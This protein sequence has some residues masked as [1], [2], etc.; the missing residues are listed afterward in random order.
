MKEIAFCG[1][2]CE[3]C[4]KFKDIF[5]EKAKEI[6]KSIK[7]SGLDRWQKHEPRE[8]EF[9]Y[10]D[11]KK[12]LKWFEKHMRCPGCNAGGGNPDCLIKKCCKDKVIKNCSVCSDFPCDKLK[13]FKEENNIDVE[14]NFKVLK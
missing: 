5:A 4:V 1:L 14:N 11:F 10:E 12:G 8:E 6:L 7:E 9:N 2:D 13:K 3:K